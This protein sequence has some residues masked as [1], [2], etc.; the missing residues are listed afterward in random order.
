MNHKSAAPL[1]VITLSFL[2]AHVVAATSQTLNDERRLLEDV[3]KREKNKP[4]QNVSTLL[5]KAERLMKLLKYAEAEDALNRLR[6]IRKDELAHSIVLKGESQLRQRKIGEAT[7]TLKTAD[8]KNMD[9][10]NLLAR[11]RFYI[12]L[13]EYEGALID[14]EE[15]SKRFPNCA[16]ICCGLKALT[17]TGMNQRDKA[18]EWCKITTERYPK[19]AKQYD[20]DKFP[21]WISTYRNSNISSLLRAYRLD[22]IFEQVGAL[23]KQADSALLDRN[24]KEAFSCLSRAI[25]I[26]P[27]SAYVLCYRA[28]AYISELEVGK[29]LQEANQAVQLEPDNIEGYRTRVTINQHAKKLKAALNDL[30][31]VVKLA[32]SA[33][34]YFR[35]ANLLLSMNRLNE[36]SSDIKAA[37]SASPKMANYL[38]CQGLICTAKNEPKTAIAV[39][40]QAL[41]LAQRDF[42][43]AREILQAR[44][45]A[46]RMIG[47]KSLADADEKKLHED[48][49]FLF[50][51]A[52]FR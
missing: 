10:K 38:L 33:E 40:S 30:N 1:L 6:P 5:G 36:A 24:Q 44:S 23:L 34:F 12:I 32:P 27:W 31:I 39:L 18:L 48:E 4:S 26:Q 20:L 45:K 42:S 11:A 9:E 19:I 35:R 51:F 49:K 3:E 14:L 43:I 22:P 13:K 41:S 17:Y 16:P 50:D 52:P 46:Y 7:R 28:R 2:F 21:T 8:R 47:N 37:L 29:A 25:R 15:C